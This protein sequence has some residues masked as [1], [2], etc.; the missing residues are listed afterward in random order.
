MKNSK[1]IT[2][3]FLAGT[4]SCSLVI[5]AYAADAP[6]EK[7][8]VVYANLDAEGNMKELNVVNIFGKGE[9][10]DYGSY[11]SV[12]M[13]NTEDKISQNGDEITFSASNDRTYY[14]GQLDNTELPWDISVEYYMDGTKYSAEEIAGKSGQ[15]EMRFKVTRNEAA[16][17]NFFDNYALQA[18]F[19]LDTNKC[20][21]IVADGATLANV[22]S[23]KQISY[24]ILPGEGIDAVIT[25]DVVDFEM[26]AAS[27]NGVPLS[28]DV[29]V[30]DQEIMDQVTKLQDAI[31]S[32][33]EGTGTLNEGTSELLDAAEQ[34]LQTGSNAL[35]T[36]SGQLHEGAWTL[37]SG[38][39]ALCAGAGSL[40]AGAEAL[41]AG[42]QRVDAG[43]GQMQTSLQSEEVKTLT[44]GVRNLNVVLNTGNPEAGQM[45]LKDG[46]NAVSGGV[47]Q[48][49]SALAQMNIVMNDGD[50]PVKSVSEAAQTDAATLAQTI[51]NIPATTTG[52]GSGISVAVT[53]FSGTA[54]VSGTVNMA[55]YNSVAITTLQNLIA[56]GNLSEEACT[57]VQNVINQLSSSQSIVLYGASIS[58]A[59]GTGDVNNVPV[60]ITNPDLTSLAGLAQ[61]TA[62][63]TAGV[64][65]A[66]NGDGTNPGIAA[67]LT[68]L[69]EKVNGTNATVGLIAAASYLADGV[70]SVAT[71]AA[72]LDEGM[73]GT[74]GLMVQ[75]KDGTSQLREGTGELLDGSQELADGTKE[76]YTKTGELLSGIT[77]IYNA[78][79][80]LRDGSGKLDRGVAELV[81]GITELYDGTVEM[82]DGTGELYE[83]TEGMDQEI[84]DQIDELLSTITGEDETVV[85]FVSDKNTNVDAVQF[86]IQ[87]EAVETE[88]E[89]VIENKEE[90][91]MT[92]WEK[93]INLFMYL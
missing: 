47:Q 86:V 50:M 61:K 40:N 48:V 24:M 53:N 38:G 89:S 4:M 68:V 71:G 21:N 75:M 65:T 34:E 90:D 93:I 35:A 33:D 2:A 16:E 1:K 28:I 49:G 55:D 69:D 10:K 76:L 62:A 27:V 31:A 57:Q 20:T 14:Q 73:N 8:E 19:A 56:S 3:V 44:G 83:E 37:K 85:S 81:A 18:A 6:S 52:N 88:E 32:L 29:E 51:V 39:T 63:E 87:T 72:S 60:T 13:L 84:S 64:N 77:E 74:N 12:K 58:G 46:A 91:K 70:Q 5:P 41:L 92:I 79:G 17:G 67:A 25:A 54:D 66:I 15:L 82:K 59:S 78:T 9:V 22:G 80:S 11:S 26:G 23:D 42:V 30:D 45:S 7:E 43:V 36:G